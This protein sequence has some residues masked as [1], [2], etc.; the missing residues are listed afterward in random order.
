MNEAWRSATDLEEEMVH[1][2]IKSSYTY[3][4]DNPYAT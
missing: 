4:K 2:D 3:T 1:G